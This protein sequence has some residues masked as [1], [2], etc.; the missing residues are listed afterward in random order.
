MPLLDDSLLVSALPAWTGANWCGVETPR[1]WN[2]ADD[3]QATADTVRRIEAL[4]GKHGAWPFHPRSG[5]ER[6]GPPRGR[7]EIASGQRL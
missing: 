4:E 2:E 7:A 1:A 6:I 5:R 3:S